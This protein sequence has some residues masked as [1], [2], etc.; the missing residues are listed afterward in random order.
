MGT[1]IHVRPGEDEL[2]AKMDRYIKGFKTAMQ[3]LF[4]TS[5]QPAW[6]MPGVACFSVT[7]NID[8]QADGGEFHATPLALGR[9]GALVTEKAG[10]FCRYLALE[11]RPGETLTVSVERHED[12]PIGQAAPVVMPR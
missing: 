9:V 3:E 1:P 2:D 4:P 8:S 6:T 7:A 11:L 12:V 5:P 10:E